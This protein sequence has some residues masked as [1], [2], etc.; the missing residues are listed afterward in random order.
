MCEE[1]E[2]ILHEL[3]CVYVLGPKCPKSNFRPL[4]L[5]CMIFDGQV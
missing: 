5:F 4:L 2:Q 1:R 3:Y